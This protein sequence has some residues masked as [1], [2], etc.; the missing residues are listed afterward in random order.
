[1]SNLYD[2]DFVAWADQQSLLLE[3]RRYNEID[4]A[5]LVEEVKDLGNKHRDD[6]STE[7]AVSIRKAYK[8]SEGHH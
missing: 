6:A 5:N 4:L 2:K 1:M 8:E 3:Q 7:M